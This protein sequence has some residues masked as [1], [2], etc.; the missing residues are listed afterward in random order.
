MGKNS[1]DVILGKLPEILRLPLARARSA[2]E[3][4]ATEIVLR[5]QRP[6]CIYTGRGRF[7]LTDKGVLTDSIKADGIICTDRKI[8]EDI[9]LRLCDYSVYAYQDEINSGFIT[10]GGGVRVGICGR[11]VINDGRIT[12]IRDI[13][14]LSFRIARDIRGCS[15][16]L[17]EMIKP[18][19]G[20]LICGEPGSGKTTL[21]RDMARELSYGYRVSLIDE[22]GELSAGSRGQHG[23]DIGLCDIYS[24]FPKGEAAIRALRSMNPEIIVCDELG[25][26]NDVDMLSLTL[27]CGAAFI[28]SVHASSMDDLRARKVTSDIIATGAF[29]YIAFLSGKS[30]AGK[31]ARLYETGGNYA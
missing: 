12:N 15:G 3:G 30:N 25:D 16:E 20:V 31:I 7:F 5:S 6:L 19:R 2:Y 17:L 13:S 29:G 11:A 4:R 27:R 1:I 14:T 23:F 8:I 21:I 9:V 22:R 24:G 10:V 18:L 28:A 26:K